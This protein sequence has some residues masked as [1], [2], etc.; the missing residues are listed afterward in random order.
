MSGDLG[1]FLRDRRATLNLTQDQVA[2]VAGLPRAHLSQIE[3]GKI[4]LPNADLRRRLAEAL[5]LRHVDLLIAAGELE[6]GELPG[7]EGPTNGDVAGLARCLD[8]ETLL[9]VIVLL[10]RLAE[11]A[12]PSPTD[13]TAADR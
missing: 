10:R 13:R 1:R 12:T 9:A 8:P 7:S 6:P 3:S 2:K 5:G 11:T 4:G